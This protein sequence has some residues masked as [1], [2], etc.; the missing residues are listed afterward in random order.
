[1]KRARNAPPIRRAPVPERD[2]VTATYVI[3]SMDRNENE[4]K[5][6]EL[7][8][9]GVL[10]APYASLAAFLVN[11]GRPVMPRYSLSGLE[12]LMSSSA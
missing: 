10:L 11:S 5:R 8:F 12:A 2:W 6:T 3:V 9:R 7:E 1:M 4:E